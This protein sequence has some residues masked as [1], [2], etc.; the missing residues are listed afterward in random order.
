MTS[1]QLQ[2][3]LE[4][5]LRLRLDASGSPEYGLTW[6]H[7][8]MASGAPI[9]AL[10]ALDRPRDGRGFI[11][12]HSAAARDW[13]DSA[14][15][16]TEAVNPDGSSRV[17]I[18]QLPRQVRLCLTPSAW[19]PCPCC[20]EW[21]CTIHGEHAHDCECP[22]IEEWEILPYE[23]GSNT[24]PF[25]A[26]MAGAGLNP[27]FSRWLQGFPAEWCEAAIR[28]HRSMPTRRRKRESEG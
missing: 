15:M 18:D 7:W 5:A 14:G 27:A 23:S 25:L 26:S 28:A 6:K 1:A 4:N 19:M 17:R 21:I 24:N 11:G 3:G 16:R 22:G 8:D 20:E 9:C 2:S 13:K 10:R 12:W